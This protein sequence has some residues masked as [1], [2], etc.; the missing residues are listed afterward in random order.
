MPGDER[1]GCQGGGEKTNERRYSRFKCKRNQK[2]GKN[3]ARKRNRTDIQDERGT[4]EDKRQRKEEKE[5]ET[6]RRGEG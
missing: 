2:R 6:R 4:V 5:E 3:K 1:G